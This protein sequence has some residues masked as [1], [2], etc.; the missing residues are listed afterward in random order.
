M[1]RDLAA[2][3]LL[4]AVLTLSA[5]NALV[6]LAGAWFQIAYPYE[7][8]YGEGIVLWQAAH[9]FDLPTA[10][11]PIDQYPFIVF[12]YP[13]V[14]HVLSRAAAFITGDLLIAGRTVSFAL[15]LGAAILSGLLAATALR[16]ASMGAGAADDVDAS[17][18][19][20]PNRIAAFAA[21]PLLMLQLA[22]L[23]WIPFMRV[24]IAAV[25]L[26]LSGLLVFLRYDTAAGRIAAAAL[27][28][29]ALFCKQTM[30]AA[31]LAALV[32]LL[33]AGNVRG[34]VT[35]MGTSLVLG[36][37]A[38]GTLAWMTNGEFVRHLFLYNSNPFNLRQLVEFAI[39]NLDD[40]GI[41]IALAL[42]VPLGVGSAG[43]WARDAIAARAGRAKLCLVCYAAAAGAVCLTAGKAGASMNYFLEWNVSCCVLAAIASGELLS[44]GPARRLTMAGVVVSLMLG[45]FAVN[46][47]PRSINYVTML[48][49]KDSTLNARAAAV[50]R[51][52]EAIAE[53][54]G[55]VLSEDLLLLQRV[56]R[57][58]PWEP[59]IITQL[60]E[61]GLFDENLALGKIRAQTFGLIVAKTLDLDPSRF[62]GG[63][64][65]L[66]TTRMR[67][68]IHD[69]YEVRAKLGAGYTLLQP[70][71][72]PR[73]AQQTHSASQ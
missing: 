71:Q 16:P 3:V 39:R 11:H 41:A 21:A 73:V 67:D 56:N 25:F 59:A 46:H 58:V 60:A 29:T 8:D 44:L 68:A 27:F 62:P 53:V 24:D 20:V 40:A 72:D 65:L 47:V 35:L 54:P 13:P 23:D 69:A 43:Q 52:A 50:T 64:H 6:F 57:E 4:P 66:Y 2:R 31:P 61:T 26:A 18:G 7:L 19:A 48:R 45:I 5:L 10:Y 14:Y 51:A 34:A 37:A 17:A 28:V 36:V 30:I 9:V 63:R 12:H 42:A 33:V 49:G 1:R 22:T 38:L 70:R 15:A 32:T 55:P